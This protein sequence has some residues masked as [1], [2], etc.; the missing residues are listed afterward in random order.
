M[1]FS[2]LAKRSFTVQVTNRAG[3]AYDV[4]DKLIIHG[5]KVAA[6][7]GATFEN[8][9]PST[10][11][12]INHVAAAQQEDVDAAVQSCLDAAKEWK[13]VS[14]MERSHIMNKF[15]D[16]I[17]ANQDELITLECEDMGKTYDEAVFD[18]NFTSSTIRYYAG[19]ATHIQGQSF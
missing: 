11:E 1:F 5:Q 2:K 13:K 8:V 4:P 15:A 3:K 17:D 6:K 7:G 16:I 19:L 14:N 10:E 18:M 9:S 12:V